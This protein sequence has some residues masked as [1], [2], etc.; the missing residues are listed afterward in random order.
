MK[1]TAMPLLCLLAVC[2]GL[3]ATAQSQ[4]DSRP[5]RVPASGAAPAATEPDAEGWIRVLEKYDYYR[6]LPGREEVASGRLVEVAAEAAAATAPRAVFTIDS[7]RIRLRHPEM[8]PFIGKAVEIRGKVAAVG[9]G[10]AAAE[11]EP[12]AIRLIAGALAPETAPAPVPSTEPATRPASRSAT[13][14]SR[15]TGKWTDIFSGEGWYK[16]Q[17][18][19]EEVFAGT[20]EAVDHSRPAKEPFAARGAFYRLGER[21]IYTGA[22]RSAVLERLIGKK[23]EIR[24]KAQDYIVD[25]HAAREIWPAAARET[26]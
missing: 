16:N 20:L 21:S 12:G 17:K 26:E 10:K 4:P 25:K 23:V 2:C 8:R 22:R 1:Y 9:A 19:E 14:T 6:R 3:Y 11:M 18:G 7:Y 24:G 5:L 15:P 13:T